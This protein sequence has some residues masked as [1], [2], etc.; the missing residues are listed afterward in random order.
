MVTFDEC[1]LCNVDS[2]N[3]INCLFM[4]VKKVLDILLT[5]NSLTDISNLLKDDDSIIYFTIFLYIC[6][7]LIKNIT[8]KSS[9]Y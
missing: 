9:K 5:V 2:K 7:V 8:K 4:S 6:L 3:I 1:K